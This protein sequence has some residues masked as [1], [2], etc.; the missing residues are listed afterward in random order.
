MTFPGRFAG[1][2]GPAILLAAGVVHA[3]TASSCR[4]QPDALSLAM[5]VTSPHALTGARRPGAG[6]LSARDSTRP[7]RSR[8]ANP[9]AARA[10]ICPQS[11]FSL[12]VKCLF[13]GIERITATGIRSR[14]L[15]NEFRPICPANP[16]VPSASGNRSRG[17]N[18][19]PGTASTVARVWRTN[20]FSTLALDTTS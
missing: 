1:M 19:R 9:L 16:P 8:A 14:R 7:L 17:V 12:P 18:N 11:L 5:S 13:A 15:L 4:P 10:Q 3:A 6:R 2:R 20:Q